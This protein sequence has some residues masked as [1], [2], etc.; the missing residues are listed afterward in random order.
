MDD[1]KTIYEQRYETYR[2]FD[3]LRWFVFQIAISVIVGIFVL[4]NPE[5]GSNIFAIGLL[6][7]SSGLLIA[8]I[9][10][11]IYKNNVV[12]QSIGIKEV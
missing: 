5:Q 12:L 6:L 4:K 8:K 1:Y 3:K 11:G 9:N 7:F 2:H 10:Y